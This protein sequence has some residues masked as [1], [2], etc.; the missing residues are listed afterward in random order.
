MIGKN[1][2]ALLCA[3]C[4]TG[5]SG[6]AHAQF[7]GVIFAIEN[8]GSTSRDLVSHTSSVSVLGPAFDPL[9]S[10]AT[11]ASLT[12]GG[13]FGAGVITYDDCTVNYNWFPLSGGTFVSVSAS[14]DCTATMLTPNPIFPAGAA[15]IKLDL[16]D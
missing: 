2:I 14:P 7:G 16:T 6:A 4:F 5:F 10:G 8:T 15:V 12:D 1:K 9:A 3:V 11:D 13:R